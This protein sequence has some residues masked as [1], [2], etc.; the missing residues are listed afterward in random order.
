M[1]PDF[2]VREWQRTARVH[3]AHPPAS[4][5]VSPATSASSASSEAGAGAGMRSRS[6]DRGRAHGLFRIALVLSG[7]GPVPAEADAE[8]A[9]LYSRASSAAKAAYDAMAKHQSCG[10][11]IAAGGG[12]CLSQP[13]RCV[14]DGRGLCGE[15][16]LPEQHVGWA[17]HG[18]CPDP[19]D[20]T[21][22]SYLHA[23][24]R[25]PPVRLQKPLSPD[26]AASCTA[27]ANL[28]SGIGG[29]A[30]AAAAADQL[31]RC[32]VVVIP[33]VFG[34]D[35]LTALRAQLVDKLG[36]A[37]RTG[38]NYGHKLEMPGVR[39]TM[40]QELTVPFKLAPLILDG[41]RNRKTRRI[42]EKLLGHP[43]TVDFVSVIVAWPGAE[44]QEFHRDAE[45]ATEAAVILFVPLDSTSVT[46][47]SAAGP[48]E[49]CL[50]THA[51]SASERKDCG[52]DPP[53]PMPTDSTVPLGSMIAF[54]PG[55]I[56]RGRH[57]PAITVPSSTDPLLDDQVGS[58]WPKASPRLML[59]I[60]VAPRGNGI[61][62]RPEMLLGGTAKSHVR[63]WR[64]A[65]LFDVG[66][67]N[68]DELDASAECEQYKSCRM[69]RDSLPSGLLDP[70]EHPH[71][72]SWH[73]G[74]AWC[75]EAQQ[76]VPDV[77][78]AC[79]NSAEHIGQSGMGGLTCPGEHVLPTPASQKPEL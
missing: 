30:A 15:G 3:S 6:R 39:G 67:D 31:E 58:R 72:S 65:S 8:R 61:R 44:A 4:Q 59:S 9:G 45:A 2:T 55:T 14:P 69:C 53:L 70:Q 21:L 37:G 23:P 22:Q 33:E 71:D 19:A 48:P 63:K 49:F 73:T 47:T 62:A 18:R 56:H 38:P 74:C 16:T 51:P 46:N 20:W 7:A 10:D 27:Q 34:K 42:L 43:P 11:C 17:G 78:A 66:S 68:A 35:S 54:D 41:L 57:Y 1:Y 76:C 60:V 79:H 50:C 25:P 75:S 24:R 29:V 52:A 32:G 28:G 5:P 64:A 26:C 13:Q 12:W 77:A 36:I 40:R